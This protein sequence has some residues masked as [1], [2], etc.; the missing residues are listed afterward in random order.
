MVSEAD[1]EVVV[2]ALTQILKEARESSGFRSGAHA[3]C[4]PWRGGGGAA[5]TCGRQGD[6]HMTGGLY[7]RWSPRVPLERR[8]RHV[9]L[10]YEQLMMSVLARNSPP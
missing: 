7:K 1:D 6:P 3:P 4:G 2:L 5:G 8:E 9:M 10:P